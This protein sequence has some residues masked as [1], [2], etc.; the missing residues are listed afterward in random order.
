MPSLDFET[1]KTEFRAFYDENLEVLNDAKASF[2][3][4]IRS[5]LVGTEYAA[6]ASGRVK[7]REESI[8][9][10]GRKYQSDLEKTERPYAIKDH[11]TDLIGLRLVCLYDDQIEPIGS[12]IRDQ[13]TV[14]GV[15]DK[16]AAIEGTEN[17]FGYKGLHLDLELDPGRAEM[18][19]YQQFA[20]YRFELQIRTIIQDSWSTLDHKIK[21]KKSITAGLKRRI[22]TL[23]ALF[24]LADREFRYVRDETLAE[25]ARAAVEDNAGDEQMAAAVG[26][27]AGQGEGEVEPGQFAPLNAFRF[28]RI[29]HHFFPHFEFEPQKVDGF[30]AEIIRLEPAISRGKFNYY[31]RE[32]IG[33]IRRYKDHFLA[34]AAGNTFNAFTEIRHCL[35]AADPEI[36]GEMLNNL[37]KEAF[38]DWRRDHEADV[39]APAPRA[40]RPRRPRR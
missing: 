4:L 32:N 20:P 5:L 8:K 16:V 39:P 26:E 27:I 14:L 36:F 9:K 25:I 3:T 33:L 30:T 18:P 40:P 35:Y 1:E 29:A 28:L 19:E 6:V 23:A 10:F 38:E 34:E 22:N 12:L 31:L 13:L 21:Y 11:I 37:A 2:I 24:E 17:A 7:D 15:T